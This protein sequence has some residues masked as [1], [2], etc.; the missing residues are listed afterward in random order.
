MSRPH[1]DNP[2]PG[3]LDMSHYPNLD[4]ELAVAAPVLK[5][6]RDILLASDL[7]VLPASTW[8]AALREA[9]GTSVEGPTVRPDL[10]EQAGAP[11]PSGIVTPAQGHAAVPAPP[12]EPQ[13]TVDDDG[14]RNVGPDHTLAWWWDPAPEDS[15]YDLTGVHPLHPG[16]GPDHPV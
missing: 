13:E 16:L 4:P 11:M 12:S 5:A 10:D 9:L 1:Q 3:W 8:V 7:T 6:L 2:S 14:G 15:Q